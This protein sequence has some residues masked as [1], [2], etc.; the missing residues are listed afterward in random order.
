M[1]IHRQTGNRQAI[2]DDLELHRYYASMD[3]Y[4]QPCHQD[5]QTINDID[6]N[7]YREYMRART[8]RNINRGQ[9]MR[10]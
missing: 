5:Q 7:I 3:D 10:V 8:V 4:P 2:V 9:G 6:D 1:T